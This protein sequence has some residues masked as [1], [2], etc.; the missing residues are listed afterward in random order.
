[1]HQRMG[2]EMQ[3]HK[4]TETT[5]V[6]SLPHHHTLPTPTPASPRTPHGTS[7]SAPLHTIVMIIDVRTA[8]PALGR[9]D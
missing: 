3:S 7:A 2:A 6:A 9:G 4:N 1:M 8:V 5:T